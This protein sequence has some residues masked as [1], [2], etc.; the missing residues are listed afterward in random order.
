MRASNAT[1][2]FPYT[3]ATN[4]LFGLAESIE[5]FHEEGL[6]NVFARHDRL[7]EATRR[8]VRVWGLEIVCRDPQCY[9]PVLTAVFLPEGHNADQFRKIVLDKFDMS[10]GTGLTKL[11]GKAFR[12]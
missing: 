3:P 6:E 10:L 9:S 2:S 8:A 12:I 7:A 11:A 5:M 1:G 4:I